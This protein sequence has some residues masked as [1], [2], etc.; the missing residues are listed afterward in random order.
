MTVTTN[1]TYQQPVRRARQ[2]AVIMD[3]AVE[4]G[5]L[6]RDPFLRVISY[7]VPGLHIERPRTDKNLSNIPFIK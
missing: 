5:S 7:D 3:S 6:S 4:D 1:S 2:S